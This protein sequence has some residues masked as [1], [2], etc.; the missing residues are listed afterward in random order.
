MS[1]GSWYNKYDP[2]KPLIVFVHGYTEFIYTK[3]YLNEL[4]HQFSVFQIEWIGD[5][6]EY[7]FAD[8]DMNEVIDMY[9]SILD[10]YLPENAHVAAFTGHCFGGELA[11][12]LCVK[13]SKRH[14][15]MP[16]VSLLDTTWTRF[17]EY[18]NGWSKIL[19]YLPMKDMKKVDPNVEEKFIHTVR[20]TQVVGQIL[21]SPEVPPYGG[22]VILHKA[23]IHEEDENKADLI[24]KY[25]EMGV[26]FSGVPD[27]VLKEFL[28]PVKIIDNEAFW[29]EEH[30]GIIVYHVDATH[31]GMLES[32]YVANYVSCLKEEL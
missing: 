15:Q 5:H 25:E 8:A 3:H 29:K 32:N 30:P 11:Y 20:M 9:Y 22:K 6:F 12:R 14:R 16:V 23:L 2:E 24:S 21:K 18:P 26:S 13:W 17:N 1:I 4:S 31:L 19:P 28:A 27:E 10:I 7:L